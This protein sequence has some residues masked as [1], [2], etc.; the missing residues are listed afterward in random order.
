[1]ASKFIQS[2]KQW[3]IKLYIYNVDSC[4]LPILNVIVLLPIQKLKKEF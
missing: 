2:K 1:M 3:Y 4:C